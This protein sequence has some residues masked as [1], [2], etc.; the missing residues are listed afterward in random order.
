[1]HKGVNPAFPYKTELRDRSNDLRR[2]RV[3]GC[4]VKG[5]GNGKNTNV[6]AEFEFTANC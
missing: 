2:E 4:T 6:I 5:S 1:M 3:K